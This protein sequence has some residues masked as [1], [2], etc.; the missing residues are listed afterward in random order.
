[1]E[2]RQERLTM[3]VFTQFVMT[4]KILG[5]MLNEAGIGFLYYYGNV[6]AGKR[7]KAIET[8][9]DDPLANVMV[10]LRSHRSL[11]QIPGI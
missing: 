10:S 9:R 4:G 8:F 11:I 2:F 5:Q 3:T 1:M 6:S 7:E